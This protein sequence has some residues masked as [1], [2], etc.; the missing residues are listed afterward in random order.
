M[1]KKIGAREP[2]VEEP[3]LV[4]KSILFEFE[5][6]EVAEP[7]ALQSGHLLELILRYGSPSEAAVE[8]GASEAF[9]RQNSKSKR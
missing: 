7:K 3:V 8:I 5:V 9:V 2:E 4:A 6:D 1:K